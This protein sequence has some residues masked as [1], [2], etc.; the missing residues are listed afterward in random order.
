MATTLI[1]RRDFLKGG[2]AAGAALTLP[3]VSWE[4]VFADAPGGV[5]DL[6]FVATGGN[7]GLSVIDVRTGTLVKQIEVGT[8]FNYPANQW[9]Y[10]SRYIWGSASG[11]S[12]VIDVF[13]G[14]IIW[15]HPGSKDHHNY[16]EVT[17]DGHYA[18]VAQRFNDH[19]IKVGADPNKPDWLQVVAEYQTYSG[20]QP[21][22]TTISPDGRYSFH[23]DVAGN[24]L[25]VL[26][27]GSFKAVAIVPVEPLVADQAKPYMCTAAPDGKTLFVENS[28]GSE[29][30]WDVSDPLH[31]VEV[32]RLAK[33]DGI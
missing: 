9:T 27:L 25:E 10:D 1:S 11:E 7:K 31:P 32:A 20:A 33:A 4:K 14:T 28:E 21:C 24:R 12:Q 29:G 22:D 23:P 3:F 15:R 2:I 16:V 19:F 30:I 5:L 17:P 6:L 18:V 8:A 13:T 26:D